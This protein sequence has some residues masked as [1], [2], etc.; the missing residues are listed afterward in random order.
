MPKESFKSLVKE[1]LNIK[2]KQ[3]LLQ[4]RESHS[5]TKQLQISG[6]MQPYLENET[7]PLSLKQLL[8]GL[9]SRTADFKFNYKNKYK[10]DLTCRICGYEEENYTHTL[11]CNKIITHA[12]LTKQECNYVDVNDIY[13]DVNKQI[14]AVKIWSKLIQARDDLSQQ[15]AEMPSAPPSL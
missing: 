7:L 9:R 5:K 6:K 15:E 12:Q 13:S 8:F 2:S 4:L 1:K 10:Q 11:R 3:F 14:T